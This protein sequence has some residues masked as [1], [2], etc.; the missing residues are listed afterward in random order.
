TNRALAREVERIAESWGVAQDRLLCEARFR[1]FAAQQFLVPLHGPARPIPLSRGGQVV[2]ADAVDRNMLDETVAGL[3]SWML[4]NVAPDG[5][6]TYKY[7]PSA[8]G[9]AQS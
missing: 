4:N 2:P 7:W 8:G 5:R 3:R 1:R 9:E 6:M